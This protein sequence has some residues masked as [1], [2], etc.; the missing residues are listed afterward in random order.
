MSSV[1]GYR[2]GSHG[3]HR[4]QQ[5]ALVTAGD[6]GESSVSGRVELWVVLTRLVVLEDRTGRSTG[7]YKGFKD[8]ILTPPSS[9]QIHTVAR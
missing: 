3:G 7:C 9:H 5:S 8:P 2:H 4:G 1:D 6:V